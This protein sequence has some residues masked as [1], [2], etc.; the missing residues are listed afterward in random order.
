MQEPDACAGFSLDD[1][2]RIRDNLPTLDNLE[3]GLISDRISL[4][5]I[6]QQQKKLRI[7]NFEI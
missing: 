7:S 1:V 3:P 2:A 6:K 4:Y 5:L